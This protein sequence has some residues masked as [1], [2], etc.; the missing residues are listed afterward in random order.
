M[1]SYR[2]PHELPFMFASWTEYRDH[3]LAN[4]VPE[5][6]RAAMQHRFGLWERMFDPSIHHNVIQAQI[7]SILVNDYEG[8]KQTTFVAANGRFIKGRGKHKRWT[9]TPTTNAE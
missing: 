2:V 9:S 6:K 1:E 3:L 7:A 5:D 8:V 4:L